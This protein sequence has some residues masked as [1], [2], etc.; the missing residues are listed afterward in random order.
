[1]LTLYLYQIVKIQV[2]AGFSKH[3]TKHVFNLCENDFEKLKNCSN[4][5]VDGPNYNFSTIKLESRL[6]FMFNWDTFS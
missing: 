2:V 1:M 6:D 3:T 5:Q 4:N